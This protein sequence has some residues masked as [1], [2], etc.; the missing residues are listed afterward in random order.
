MNGYNVLARFPYYNAGA[1]EGCPQRPTDAQLS[2]PYVSSWTAEDIWFVSAGLDARLVPQV[3]AEDGASAR[4]WA[5]L[6]QV[7]EPVF[8]TLPID[9]VL[10]QYWAC[11]DRDKNAPADPCPQTR[12][13]PETGWNQQA[14]QLR[15]LGLPA[16][17]PW[18]TDVRWDFDL[19]VFPGGS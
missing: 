13:L 10:T 7:T 4:Q 6:K 17:L 14:Q 9:G 3:Y 8:G 12:N 19:S 2:G 16:D 5:T 15:R 18:L 1:C 11:K